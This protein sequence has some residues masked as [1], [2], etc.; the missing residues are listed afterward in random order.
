MDKRSAPFLPHS[1]L[2][3]RALCPGSLPTT[4]FP[5]VRQCRCQDHYSPLCSPSLCSGFGFPSRQPAARCWAGHHFSREARRPSAAPSFHGRPASAQHGICPGCRAAFGRAREGG[6][7]AGATGYPHGPSSRPL[8]FIGRLPSRW[9]W[10]DLQLSTP[11]GLSGRCRSGTLK[12][13]RL[14]QPAIRV[15]CWKPGS[16]CWANTCSAWPESPLGPGWG[17]GL[18]NLVP[19]LY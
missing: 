18:S 15:A 1:P 3:S 8:S 10:A 6:A 13:S 4:A 5:L 14:R 11:Q 17:L 9:P 7:R 12:T 2:P 16:C 19:C